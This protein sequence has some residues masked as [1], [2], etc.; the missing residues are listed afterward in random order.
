MTEI[1][2]AS[3]AVAGDYFRVLPQYLIPIELAQASCSHFVHVEP[4]CADRLGGNLQRPNN[5][6]R[7]AGAQL[8]FARENGMD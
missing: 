6:R 2:G 5:F 8:F 1:A 4:T 3:P 7:R